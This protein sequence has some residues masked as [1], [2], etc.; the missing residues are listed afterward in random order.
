MKLFHYTSVTHLA[1]IRASGVIR[2]SESN[3][4]SPFVDMKPYGLHVGPDVVWLTAQ[5]DVQSGHGLE[6]APVD[7]FAVRI[8]IEASDAVQWRQFAEARGINRQWYRILDKVANYAAKHWYVLPRSIALSEVTEI[9]HMREVEGLV[10]LVLGGN[11]ED[12]LG[13]ALV[14]Q[15]LVVERM[16]D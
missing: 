13:A 14:A 3:I 6:G 15:E 12:F 1:A 2:P 16:G 10:V 4:G 9:K 8:T 5:D 7:K 11:L